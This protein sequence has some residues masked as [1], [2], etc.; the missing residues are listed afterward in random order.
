MDDGKTWTDHQVHFRYGKVHTEMITLRNGDIL[1]TYA[2]RMGELEG[3]M[4]HGIEAVLS[5][6]N[7]RTWDWDNRFILFRC[8]DNLNGQDYYESVDLIDAY[9]PQTII[10][11]SL[12]GEP[13]PIRN[14]AP[15]RMRIERQLG[16]KHAKYLTAIEAVASL[17]DIGLGQGGYW[18]DRAGYQWYAGI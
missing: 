7:G 9:H 8:A 13:L 2:A 12:N 4:Y 10:A 14:G 1:L 15:M 16:Y 3:K 5:R 11:H 6:D 17:D 18:E